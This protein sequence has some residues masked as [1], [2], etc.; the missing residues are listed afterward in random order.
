MSQIML[1]KW[2]PVLD[3]MFS[4]YELEDE[5]L[6]MVAEY[7]ENNLNTSYSPS[8]SGIGMGP[9]TTPTGHTFPSNLT[10]SHKSQ[11]DVLSVV[12]EFKERLSQDVD[13]RVDVKNIYYN[14]TIKRI[15]YELANGDSVYIESKPLVMKDPDYIE[16]SK[17][18]FL[19][20]SDPKN[21]ILRRYKIEEIKKNYE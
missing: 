5:I 2:K 14:T 10:M 15:V 21:P 13:I 4:P 1:K 18:L 9:I 12:R 20:I 11:E 6:E 19:S 17:R 8:L 16:K 7:L 3:S